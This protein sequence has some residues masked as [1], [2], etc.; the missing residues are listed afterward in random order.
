MVGNFGTFES[1]VLAVADLKEMR[2]RR[3]A[4]VIKRAKPVV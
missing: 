2:L 4:Q 1:A 3:D